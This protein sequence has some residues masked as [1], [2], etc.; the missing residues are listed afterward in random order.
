MKKRLALLAVLSAS[1]AA[2]AAIDTTTA[3]A[4]ISDAQ[5][6]MVAVLAA[7]ITFVAIKWGYHKIIGLFGR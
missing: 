5:A 7:M 3:T 2:N 1:L 4:G 6:G